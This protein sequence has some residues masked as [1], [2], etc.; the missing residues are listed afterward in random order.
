MFLVN[1]QL[2]VTNLILSGLPSIILLSLS[3]FTLHCE[4]DEEPCD[5][6]NDGDST[7]DGTDLA[8]LLAS[9]NTPDG[10][11]TGDNQTDGQDLAVV[12]ANWG[13]CDDEG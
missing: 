10:D 3:F 12:L 5:G 7:V 4:S 11:L 9:W 13:P 6:D 1:F 2:S 8:Y